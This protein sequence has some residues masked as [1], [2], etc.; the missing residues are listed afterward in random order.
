MGRKKRHSDRADWDDESIDDLTPE[1]APQPQRTGPLQARL[2]ALNKQKISEKQSTDKAAAEKKSEKN[3]ESK[4]AVEAK[5][6]SQ[7]K[8][9]EQSKTK[10]QSKTKEKKESR[11]SFTLFLSYMLIWITALTLLA[12]CLFA[13][14]AAARELFN[15]SN[16]WLKQYVGY[17]AALIISFWIYIKQC[18]YLFLVKRRRAQ[19]LS[20]LWIYCGAIWAFVF[21]AMETA[22]L[23][24]GIFN[25]SALQY[26]FLGLNVFF[27]GWLNSAV[28][29][30]RQ[31][32][33]IELKLAQSE[34][35]I[36][37]KLLSRNKWEIKLYI[38]LFYL[39]FVYL[40]TTDLF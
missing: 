33:L 16:D 1:P 34:D 12:V 5:T 27:V 23:T 26:T 9:K 40:A 8:S 22:S 3:S 14:C 29:S 2:A 31:K 11:S 15:S 32:R 25:L 28:N 17:P 30:W 19:S 10:N 38:L 18:Q 39:L 7:A 13:S 4:P 6:Q 21:A 24:R 35:F 20:K 36:P 37:I